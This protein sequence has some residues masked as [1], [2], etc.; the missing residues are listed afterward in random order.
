[1][2]GPSI[3]HA[4]MPMSNTAFT[5][6]YQSSATWIHFFWG[7]GEPSSRRKMQASAIEHRTVVVTHNT[8][9]LSR[10]G[11][12]HAVAVPFIVPVEC[13]QRRAK[14]GMLGVKVETHQARRQRD[15]PAWDSRS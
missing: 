12:L 10:M 15:N 3:V 1:M 11:I 2:Y 4:I 5:I 8:A 13:G 7:A 14:D 6:M 9:P